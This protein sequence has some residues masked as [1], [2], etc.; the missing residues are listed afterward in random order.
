MAV[1][2]TVPGRSL[3]ELMESG[4]AISCENAKRMIRDLTDISDALASAGIIHRDV[5]PRNFIVSDN[6]HVSIIDFQFAIEAN[7]RTESSI[8]AARHLELLSHLGG[9]S[10]VGY[11][12]WNDRT[13]MA[14][15]IARLPDCPGKE[16]ALKKLE[17][18]A[19]GAD[20]IAALPKEMRGELAFRRWKLRLKRWVGRLAGKRLD[21]REQRLE[22]HL[23]RVLSTWRFR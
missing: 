12:V 7:A 22:R 9:D 4:E 17:S 2:E 20:Y 23:V 8:L 11:G 21:K 18:A 15:I 13:A 16:R 3:Q 10:A 5:R 14:A 19:E 6:G 1:L